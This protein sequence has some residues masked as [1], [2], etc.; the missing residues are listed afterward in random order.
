MFKVTIVVVKRTC[1]LSNFIKVSYLSDIFL[2]KIF[3][4]H[5]RIYLSIQIG[6]RQSLKLKTLSTF[7][8]SSS[9]SRGGF[10]M[11][12]VNPGSTS[13][14]LK[15]EMSHQSCFAWPRSLCF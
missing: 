1:V 4:V 5:Q 6:L 3:E 7:I 8:D 12:V 9:V 11:A 15:R 13:F 10:Y 14:K 2:Q